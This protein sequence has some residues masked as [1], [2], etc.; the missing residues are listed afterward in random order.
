MSAFS[1]FTD[2]KKKQKNTQTPTVEQYYRARASRLSQVRYTCL[3]L[4]V[5]FLV[6]GFVAHGEEL[7]LDQFRYMLKFID[8]TEEDS[9]ETNS[10]VRYDF[11]DENRGTLYRGDVAVLNDEGLSIYGWDGNRLFH[12]TFRMDDPRMASTAQN[13][14][15]YDLGGNELRVFNS[16]SQV[17]KFSMEYPIYGF[18]ACDAGNFALISSEKNYRNTVLVYDEHMRQIFKRS[19]SDTYVDQIALSPDG[20]TVLALGRKAQG[21]D[22]LTVLQAFSIRQEDPLFTSTLP[23]ELPLRVAYL[24]DERYA[25]LT[26]N[27]LR[28]F[29]AGSAEPDAVLS[30]DDRTLN[31]CSFADG[32]ILLTFSTQTLSGETVLRVYN[33]LAEQTFEAHYAG[34]ILHK[35]LY[36]DSVCV[37]LVGELFL[38]PLSG[39]EAKRYEVGQDALCAVPDAYGNLILFEKGRAYDL[40]KAGSPQN[41]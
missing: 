19:F 18:S 28:C 7:T 41:S 32:R 37:L 20:S 33:A 17:A 35:T 2:R 27:A 16:L 10:E 26:S 34:D 30:F 1:V 25:V 21:G 3:L 5:L 4:T 14:F 22:L 12:E 24:S 13:L 31:G 11:A 9:P 40:F 15:V 6:Y 39:G 8:L 29:P 36:G 23:G 38:T